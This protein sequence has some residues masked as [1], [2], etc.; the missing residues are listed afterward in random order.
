MSQCCWRLVTGTI[1]VTSNS[2]QDNNQADFEG[3]SFVADEG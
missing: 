3:S 1:D 2:R